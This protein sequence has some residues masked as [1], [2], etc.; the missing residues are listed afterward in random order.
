MLYG[1]LQSNLSKSAYEYQE[2][3]DSAKKYGIILDDSRCLNRSQYD[4]TLNRSYLEKCIGIQQGVQI[5]DLANGYF[6]HNKS[7]QKQLV[8]PCKVPKTIYGTN[9]TFNECREQLGCP[10]V[11]K[12]SLSS[13]G[14]GV[15]K[16]NTQEDFDKATHC[17]IFQEMI[18]SSVGTD[19]RIWCLGGEIIGVM[20][21]TNFDDFKAN[22]HQGGKGSIYP[23]NNTIQNIA[24]TIYNQ[25]HLDIMGIDLLFSDK[26]DVYYFCELNVNPG[27]KEFDN[28]FN[29]HTA[30]KI[31]EYIN[32]KVNKNTIQNQIN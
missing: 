20:R 30:D 21:R 23:I 22:A 8:L 19:L 18:W 26:K 5:N 2:L 24:K 3:M 25:T 4:F 17:D 10:F 27:F 14:C 28:T 29:I 11:A 13:G 16:I 6:W 9:L 15:F 7:R 32:K 31:F 12:R 1:I